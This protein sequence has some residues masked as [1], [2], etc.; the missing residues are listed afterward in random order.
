[1][2]NNDIKQMDEIREILRKITSVKQL[3]SSIA[4]SETVSRKTSQMIHDFYIDSPFVKN[5]SHNVSDEFLDVPT[6]NLSKLQI[7]KITKRVE[8]E[9]KERMLKI[10]LERNKTKPKKNKLDNL[11]VTTNFIRHK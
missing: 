4:R 7:E 1:M 8:E 9:H 5:H 2:E 6:T 3:R 10:I 11:P